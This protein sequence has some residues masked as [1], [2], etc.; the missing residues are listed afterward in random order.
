MKK[1]I[2]SALVALI[3]AFSLAAKVPPAPATSPATSGEQNRMIDNYFSGESIVLTPQEKASLAITKRWQENSDVALKPV[4]GPDGSVRFIYGNGQV[5]IVCAIVNSC[6]LELQP[7]ETINSLNAGDPARWLFD[8]AVSGSGENEVQHVI[9]T[10]LDVGLNTTLIITTNRRTYRLKVRSHKTDYMAVVNFSYPE[11]AMRKFDALKRREA[12]EIRDNT[13]P[14]TGEAMASLNFDYQVSGSAP[15]KPV[16]VYNDGKKTYI[17]M[18]HE[19]SQTEAPTLLVQR[20]D[21]GVFSDEVT[22]MVNYR[23]KGDRFE[24]DSLFDRA[25]L[26]SGVGS[27]QDRVTITKGK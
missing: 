7:G 5:S 2:L 11:D 25:I 13:I 3:P 22:V 1:L 17:Q 20:K 27:D 16:R 24:V 4:A 8:A 6:D 12:K 26:V 10:P 21:G 19:M 15:W 18:S 23:I 14:E 9:I